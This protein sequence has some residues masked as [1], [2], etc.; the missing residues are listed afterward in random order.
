MATIEGTRPVLAEI[1]A[2]VVPTQLA[3][4]RRVGQGFDYNRLQLIAAV[5]SKQLNL[6]LAGYD[7]YV[8]ITGGLRIEEPAADLGVALAIFSS[9]KNIPIPPKTAVFGE[10]GLLGEI[11]PVAQA[12]KRIKEARRLGYSNLISPDEIASISQVHRFFGK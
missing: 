10:M 9:Y 11:R 4:P 8:N 3:I 12:E 1:Q 5:L 6:P 2:L 7:I